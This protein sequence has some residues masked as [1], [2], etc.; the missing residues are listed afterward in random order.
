MWPQMRTAGGCERSASEVPNRQHEASPSAMVR[1][2][3]IG[4]KMAL[5]VQIEV[6]QLADFWPCWRCLPGIQ[7]PGEEGNR[8]DFLPAC[9]LL[10]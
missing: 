6:A 5:Q 8:L 10:L 1:L 4:C 3:Q 9:Y 7:I 2:G